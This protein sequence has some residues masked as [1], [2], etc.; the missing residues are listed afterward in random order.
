MSTVSA[1]IKTR[2]E[3]DEL[4]T[5]WPFWGIVKPNAYDWGAFTR[6]GELICVPCALERLDRGEAESADIFT[7]DQP[8]SSGEY[9]EAHHDYF[10]SPF[11]MNCTTEG[12]DTNRLMSHVSGETCLCRRCY[13]EGLMG[14]DVYGFERGAFE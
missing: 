11:C 5:N 12:D 2:D 7:I 10:I 1:T 8:L 3:H 14:R 9:C 6:E 13:L 4:F